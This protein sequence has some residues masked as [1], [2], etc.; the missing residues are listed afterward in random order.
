MS[1]V[2]SIIIIFWA[3]TLGLITYMI[4]LLQRLIDDTISKPIKQQKRMP[5]P[6]PPRPHE[7][8]WP[9]EEDFEIQE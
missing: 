6:P 9:F 1:P 5:P 7:Q 8:Y 3:V 4:T 2:E